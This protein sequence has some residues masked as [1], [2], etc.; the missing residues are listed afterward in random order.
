MRNLRTR[1]YACM[2]DRVRLPMLDSSR[3]YGTTGCAACGVLPATPEHVMG[4]A[5]RRNDCTR[6][7]VPSDGQAQDRGDEPRP[8][9]A[10][11]EPQARAGRPDERRA[12]AR[13]PAA[14]ARTL[15]PDQ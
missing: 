14:A 2:V 1:R 5:R 15:A 13:R 8:V 6:D 12:P 4:A 7:E 9:H 11:R 10:R 3:G